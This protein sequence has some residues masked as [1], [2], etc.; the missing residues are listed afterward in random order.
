M[1]VWRDHAYAVMQ[2]GFRVTRLLVFS[3]D[4][5]LITSGFPLAS[6]DPKVRRQQ[7]ITKNE[8]SEKKRDADANGNAL[9]SR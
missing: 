4:G 7:W 8:G 2:A 1:A 5:C 6:W 3:I 9:S